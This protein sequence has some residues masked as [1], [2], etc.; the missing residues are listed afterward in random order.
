ML[1]T[2]QKIYTDKDYREIL[3]KSSHFLIF[4]LLGFLIAY[5]F[6]FYVIK[7]FGEEA[8][9]YVA[10]GLTLFSILVVFGK[11]GFVAIVLG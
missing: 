6:S 7:K 10:L 8:Y 4:R 2:I 3:F 11:M 9:G 5:G 1:K